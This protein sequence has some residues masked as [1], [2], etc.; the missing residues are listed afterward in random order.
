MIFPHLPLSQHVCNVSYYFSIYRLKNLLI[1][2]KLVT[3]KGTV[4]RA[5]HTKLICEYLAFKCSHC[6]GSQLIKQTD[7][8]Y[9]LPTRCPT[10]GCR[11]VSKFSPIINSQF[12][13]NIN[14]QIIKIQELLTEEVY[15]IELIQFL[16]HFLSNQGVH[17]SVKKISRHLPFSLTIFV[18]FYTRKVGCQL[19]GTNNSR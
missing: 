15:S 9:T 4:I 19:P 7:G 13:R 3:L 18:H 5:A 16:T 12:N 17:S 6:E 14:W 2:G 11:A 10:K 8:C 1:L